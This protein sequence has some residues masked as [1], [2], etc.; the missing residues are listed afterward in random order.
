MK[1]VIEKAKEAVTRGSGDSKRAILGVGYLLVVVSIAYSTAV[2][3]IGVDSIE[4]KI[5]LLPQ[6]FFAGAILLKAFS[7]LY[8]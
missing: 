1:Q 3:L 8:K 5:A 6:V 2:I 7:K 4:S